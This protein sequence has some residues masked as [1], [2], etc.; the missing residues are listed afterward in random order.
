MVACRLTTPSVSLTVCHTPRT[1]YLTSTLVTFLLARNFNRSRKIPK[2][3]FHPY[4]SLHCSCLLAACHSKDV[5]ASRGR[6]VGINSNSSCFDPTCAALERPAA[7]RCHIFT[8]TCLVF[9]FVAKITL[10]SNLNKKF[11]VM[12]ARGDKIVLS[13]SFLCCLQRICFLTLEKYTLLNTIFKSVITVCTFY[14]CI[15]ATT[16]I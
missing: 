15:N 9:A 11:V 8:I 3:F 10:I 2:Q 6:L 7:Q 1:F 14:V 12:H 5:D 4:F 16:I 13:F